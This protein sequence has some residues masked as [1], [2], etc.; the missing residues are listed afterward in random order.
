MEENKKKR[1]I[2]RTTFGISLILLGITIALQT[3]LPIDL[4]RYVLMAWPLIIISIGIEIL[5]YSNKDN[6]ETKYDFLGIILTGIIVFFGIG[7][8]VLNYGVNKILYSNAMTEYLTQ[9][10]EYYTNRYFDSKLNIISLDDKAVK[11]HIVED[12][13]LHDTVKATIKFTSTPSKNIV[14][15]IFDD[16]DYYDEYIDTYGL[17]EDIATLEIFDLPSNYNA[18]EITI[19]TDSKDKITTN[20]LFDNF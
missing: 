10:K 13:N 19:L 12:K 4:L 17:D 16:N 3:I 7:F 11:L 9:E 20:G 2:G 5:Y 6:F 14:A 15:N 8:S 18:I 1:L